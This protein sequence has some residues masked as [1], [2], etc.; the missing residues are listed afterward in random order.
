[1][2]NISYIIPLICFWN[3]I[4]KETLKYKQESTAKNIVHLIH[5]LIF[6]LHHN[7]NY[8][9]DYAI[10]ISIGFYTYDLMYII[11]SILKMKIKNDFIKH[12]PYIIH[13][14]IAIYLLN[15]SFITESK[16]ILLGG[17]NILE[18]SNIM[19]Y[20]SHHIH[21]EYNDHLE[22]NAAS[23]FIQLL[24]YSYFRM[25]KFFSFVYE[26]KIYFFR[27]NFTTQTVIVMLYFMGVIWSYKLTKKNINNYHRLK[28]LYYRTTTTVKD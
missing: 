19:L 15:A 17:Y 9:I 14:L 25:I 10:H 11:S 24:W 7:Y 12:F 22:M 13:H 21:K 1:M 28:Q 23:E 4:L 16:Q 26:N 8:N 27:F 6:I 2:L 18:M 3:S 5:S 20:V